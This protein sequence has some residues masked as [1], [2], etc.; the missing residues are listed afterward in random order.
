MVACTGGQ[1]RAVADDDF[2]T[3]IINTFLLW[4]LVEHPAS[5]SPGF[6]LRILQVLAF[7]EHL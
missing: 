2:T 5:A 6:S 7:I 3:L 1:R 4:L